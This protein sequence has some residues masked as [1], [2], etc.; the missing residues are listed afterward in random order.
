M[1]TLWICV[2][3]AV[4]QSDP[5]SERPPGADPLVEEAGQY[6]WEGPQVEVVEV[7]GQH[8]LRQKRAEIVRRME[9]MG[10]RA[11]DRRGQIVFRPPESWMGKVSLTREGELLFGRPVLALRSGQLRAHVYDPGATLSA[12]D[13]A[14]TADAVDLD[15]SAEEFALSGDPELASR[16]I[17]EATVVLLPSG[18]RLARVELG[19][20]QAIGEDVGEYR[21]ILWETRFR[22]RLYD[23]PD[24][25][26]RLWETGEAP[27]GSIQ[28]S[29]E[30]RRAWVL[31]W[32][33][34]RAQ[35]EEGRL[36]REAAEVWLRATVMD[37]DHPVTSAEIRAAEA[38]RKDGDTLEL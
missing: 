31:D 29:P 32:W 9:K 30:A 4:A 10:W 7:W 34:T 3:L 11:R 26:D 27:D 23:L 21:G 14:A 2:A 17:P 13:A 16:V 15:W 35:T 22:E 33:A 1:L 6:A 19:V 8:A 38:R 36:M 24:Q 12:E 37:S 28:Q 20:L 5:S 18:D 25:L